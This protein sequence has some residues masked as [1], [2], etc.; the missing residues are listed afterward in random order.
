M[1]SFQ[2][3]KKFLDF[4]KTK[5]HKI[6]PSSSLLPEDSTVL[7][8]SAG[9]QQFL[10]YLIG[11]KNSIEDFG[12]RRL[13]SCQKCFRTD[14]I[15]K[16]GDDTHH[17][18]FEMLGNWS[19]GEDER[20]YF[21]EGA[22][23]Y[24]LEFFI[25]E[26]GLN[27]NKI[28]VTIFKG[29]KGIPEDKESFKLWQENGISKEKIRKFGMEENFWG[30]VGG[31][32]GPCGPSS[33]IYYDRGERFGCKSKDCGPNCP[34]CSRLFEL[35]NL[36]FMEYYKNEDGSYEK[37]P[38]KNID[39]GIGFERLVT[40]L[41]K[42]SSPYET[43][44][45]LPIYN[46]I[47]F[48]SKAYPENLNPKLLRILSDHIRASAFLISEG[49]LPSN[50]ERGYI[51]RRLLRRCIRYAQLLKLKEHWY[52]EPIK[53]VVEIYGKI[54]PELKNNEEKIITA[55][56]NEEEKFSKTLKAGLKELYK[57]F[58][59]WKDQ[60]VVSEKNIGGKIKII[61]PMESAKKLGK[62]LFFVYQSYGFP[63]E[64]SLEEFETFFGE[65]FFFKE[66]SKGE[67]KDELQKIEEEEFRK[68]QEVSRRGAVRK[69]GGGGK[70]S[71]KLHTATHLL[72]GAL[73]KILGKEVR[74]MGSDI[75][76]KRL[77]FDFSFP[78]KLTQE[79]IKQIENLVNHKIKENLKVKLEEIPL[80][81]ALSSGALAFFKER[82][83]SKVKVYTILNPETGEVFSKEICAG[84]HVNQTSELGQFRIQKE[85]SIGQ[86]KRR[87]RAILT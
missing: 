1:Q 71:P 9:V 20:G 28:W 72:H 68:H 81:K 46:Q 37:L 19:I 34:N 21:K 10:P 2:I 54:Y 5:G 35:W 16:V 75:T 45:F 3:R 73:R 18:F 44:L 55:I 4:F 36:V 80:E 50:M 8:T 32:A 83:P 15:Q 67:F 42:E 64:L 29:E 41:Q 82:Y 61:N 63:I 12:T 58:S 33:E 22:I 47:K 70:L 23:K 7:F 39:T 31:K 26:F 62:K 43:D 11:Q 65:Q 66:I 74:Q 53:A 40:V 76:E 24:A 85:E 25:N 78:R 87:I 27:K 59:W 30:P 57:I 77:R 38:Q 56:Q 14:D 6:M 49:V 60:I 69:F 48:S 17:T 79:E 52:V 13:A 84:P 51:L 86:G